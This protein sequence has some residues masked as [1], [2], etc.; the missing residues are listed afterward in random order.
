VSASGNRHRLAVDIG[1]TFVD[2]ISF[3][4]RTG[5]VDLHKASTTPADPSSGVLDAVAGLPVA[6]ADVETFVHGTTLG[7][8]AIL[9]RRGAAVGLITNEGFR[10]VLEVARANV[11]DRAMY[12]FGY[13]PPPPVVRRRH[14]LGVPGRLDAQGAEVV[15]LDE[16]AVLAAAAELVERYGLTSVALCFLHSYRNPAHE[17]RAAELIRARYPHVS[18]TASVDISREYR[19]YERTSTAVL[20]AY[21]KPLLDDYVVRLEASFRAAGFDGAFHVLR[22]G[23]GAMTAEL[24]RDAPLL[25]VLSGPAGGIAGASALARQMGWDRVIS[26]DVG[27]TSVDACVL[28]GGRAGDAYEADIDGLPLQIPV[29][30]I[31]TIGAGGG[32]IA[33]ADAGLLRVGP[34]SAGAVPGP[35]CYGNGG[36]D[37]TV[38]DAALVLGM[39][40]AGSFL[41]GAM[42]IDAAAAEKAVA[43]KI[44]RPLGLD[45]T[46]AAAAV[47]RV[48]V[49]RTMSAL[50][51]ITVEKALDP[52]SFRLLAFGGAGPLLAPALGRELGAEVVVPRFPAAFSAL[53]M[54][55]TDLEYDAAATVLTP[56]DDAGLAGLAPLFDELAGEVAGTLAEQGVPESDRRVVPRLDLR[57][58]GQEHTLTIELRPDDDA[59]ALADRFGRLHA[60]RHGHRLAEPAEVVTV[61]VRGVG[62]LPRPQL[63]PVPAATGPA[64]PSGRRDVYDLAT[65]TVIRTPVYE[66]DQL[67]A[68]TRLTGP[69]VVSEPTSTT[70]LA[71]DQQ[72]TVDTHG[73]LVVTGAA[74]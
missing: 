30:D 38:T 66:R 52:R 46:R 4:P 19:E 20:D 69:L 55:M 45:T 51:E 72:L 40:D 21:V 12:D 23:G 27:G 3:D 58:R 9:Q 24:A 15:P 64:T 8:N 70:V 62:E 39:L 44:G 5:A 42:Q 50:R 35:A 16:Q 25:T 49:A 47:I 29:F 63:P 71:S 41:G 26:F 1:G 56:L 67:G 14:R 36:E 65:D 11:P 60:E 17:R 74:R 61:R 6:L 7:L 43:E 57:Y 13:A 33:R 68:G 22:S 59:A 54:L 10:D 28:E 31:R 18:V 2:A 53:G 32:S 73:H 37:P 34:Q 48:L